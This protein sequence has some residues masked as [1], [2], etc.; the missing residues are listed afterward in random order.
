MLYVVGIGPGGEKYFTREAEEVLNKVDLIVCYTGYRRYIERFKKEIYTTGMRG[1]IERVRYALK[2]GERRDVAL[3]SS[4]DATI[5]GM[6]SLV[7]ELAE[8]EGYKVPIRI[9]SGV[10]AASASSAILG[11]P[12][13]HDFVVVSLSDLLTPLETILK[14][15]RCALE[16]DFVLA[17]Y[18]P[19]SK[20][21]KKPFL[22]T[23]EVIKEYGEKRGVDYIVGIVKNAGRE[24]EEYRITKIGDICN[25]LE[26]YMKFID[27]NT[28]LIVGNTNTRI[29]LNK[30]VTPRGYLN[31]YKV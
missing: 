13:N 30:M 22:K 18:N 24:G 28:T 20:T 2:E 23:L 29:I 26:E 3:V 4:G 17:I 12:L 25:H 7:Y 6:A 21:R 8:K 9:V 31:K 10:T 27:M 16:G 15:V 14:R 1:E 5:Y 19:V 11:A